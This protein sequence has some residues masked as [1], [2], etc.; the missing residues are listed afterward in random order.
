[1]ARDNVPIA[2]LTSSLVVDSR[3]ALHERPRFTAYGTRLAEHVISSSNLAG[4]CFLSMSFGRWLTCFWLN[5]GLFYSVV[6]F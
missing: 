1:M 4:K 3:C 5:F 6:V 2:S